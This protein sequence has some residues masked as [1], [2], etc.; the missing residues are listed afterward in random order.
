M[1]IIRFTLGGKRIQALLL[2]SSISIAFS[3]GDDDLTDVTNLN[4]GNTELSVQAYGDALTAQIANGDGNGID[5]YF[6]NSG[7]VIDES[8]NTYFAVNG[9]H[10]VNQG[11]YSSYYTKS[12]VEA[13]L[14]T[15]QIVNVWS[16]DATTL[17]REVDMEALTFAEGTDKL[18]VG[19]EYNFIYELDLVSGVVTREWNL[20][21]IAI[22][23]S[24]DRGIE[25]L[26]YLNGFFY[27]GIQEER[28]VYQLDLHLEATEESNANYQQVE[29][30]SSFAVSSSPSGLFAAAD[31]SLYMVAFGGGNANQQIYKYDLDGTLTCTLTV[32]DVV[33]LQQAD[34]IFL[35][36]N[37]AYVYLADSQGALNGLSSVYRIEWAALECL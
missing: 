33:D 16:F 37:E 6:R 32:P 34:G 22:H 27:A 1:A 14:E 19:D 30:I 13:S 23:T 31:G 18:Y 9:V 15:D 29:S 24:T 17:G 2:V 36:S 7:I 5:N 3:C 35:D 26:T 28:R 20:Q 10:P 8:S 12:I 11:D 21:D 25:S 4:G